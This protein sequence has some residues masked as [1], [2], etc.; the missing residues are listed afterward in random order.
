MPDLAE[1]KESDVTDSEADADPT[2]QIQ[3]V[4]SSPAFPSVVGRDVRAWA[5]Q[6]RLASG[7]SG[8]VASSS[9]S[10]GGGGGGPAVGRNV[11][12]RSTGMNTD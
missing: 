3:P 6:M 7:A 11:S 4:A 2:M 8:A 5:E 10:S 9:S 1:G 12:M